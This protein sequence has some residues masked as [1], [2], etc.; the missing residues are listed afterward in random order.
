MPEIRYSK[1]PLCVACGSRLYDSGPKFV[2]LNEVC[3]ARNVPTD[4]VG[5]EYEVDL[6]LVVPVERIEVRVTHPG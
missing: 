4:E 3:P 2:C 5:I 1:G 6:D